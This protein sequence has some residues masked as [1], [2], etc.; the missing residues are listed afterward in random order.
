MK[1]KFNS[2]EKDYAGGISVAELRELENIPNAGVAVAVNG[3]IVRGSDQA[4]FLLSEG[5][6]VVIIGAAYG[7]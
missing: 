3:R 2:V 1:I 6:D 5:D 4:T 7:G